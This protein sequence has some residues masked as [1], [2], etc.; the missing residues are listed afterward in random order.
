[1]VNDSD[2]GLNASTYTS[3]ITSA[4]AFARRVQAGSVLVNLPPSFRADHMPYGGVKDS[5]QGVEGVKSAVAELD[6]QKLVV[7]DS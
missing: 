1:M 6:H 4:M 5:G 3:S 7:L 2:F